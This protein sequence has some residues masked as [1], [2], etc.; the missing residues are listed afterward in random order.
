MAAE[1][2]VYKETK[3]GFLSLNHLQSMYKFEMLIIYT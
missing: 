3:V 1:E 2:G